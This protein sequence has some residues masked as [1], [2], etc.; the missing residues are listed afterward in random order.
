[1]IGL[2]F[3]RGNDFGGRNWHVELMVIG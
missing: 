1:V 3:K 2:L